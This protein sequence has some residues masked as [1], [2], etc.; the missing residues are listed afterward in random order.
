M[1][2]HRGRV[3]SFRE[4]RSQ[5]GSWRLSCDLEARKMEVSLA[6]GTRWTP[7]PRRDHASARTKHPRSD[8]TGLHWTLDI[9]NA[10]VLAGPATPEALK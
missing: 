7:P 1:S 2:L 4:E 3:I 10:A 5:R 8:T 6:L 9:K